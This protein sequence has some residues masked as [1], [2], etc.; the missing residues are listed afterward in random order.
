MK[1][2]S[3]LT[4][5]KISIKMT[6]GRWLSFS[7]LRCNLISGACKRRSRPRDGCGEGE[8]SF[9]YVESDVLVGHQGDVG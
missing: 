7:S 3:W 9:E 5:D 2:G 6:G 1:H 4:N 8:V